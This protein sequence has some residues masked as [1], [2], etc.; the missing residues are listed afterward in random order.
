M[1]HILHSVDLSLTTKKQHV[2][3]NLLMVGVHDVCCLA[4]GPSGDVSVVFV[5]SCSVA[6]RALPAGLVKI[7]ESEPSQE[8][9]YLQNISNLTI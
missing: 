9:V 7:W 3:E 1:V 5:D 4:A 8:V 6:N 2:R